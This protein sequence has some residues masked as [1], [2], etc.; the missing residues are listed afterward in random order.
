[1]ATKG[2]VPA[3]L[4]QFNAA[5]GTI[6]FSPEYAGMAIS[7]IMYITNVLSGVAT[8]IY[9]FS[10]PLKGGTFNSATLTL[11]LAFSTVGMNDNDPLQII[12][13]Y[14][15]QGQ[16]DLAQEQVDHLAYV[17][18]NLQS[19]VESLDLI[20]LAMDESNKAPLSVREISNERRDVLNS[21]I[22]S[23]APET[24]SKIL[25]NVNEALVIDTSGYNSIYI[26]IPTSPGSVN[27]TFQF[28]ISNDGAL[29]LQ[30]LPFINVGTSTTTTATPGTLVSFTVATTGYYIAPATAKFFRVILTA[31]TAGSITPQVVLR[32]N[33]IPTGPY[34]QIPV[35][36]NIGFIAG[37]TPQVI[38]ATNTSATVGTSSNSGFPIGG[39]YQPTSNP[40]NAASTLSTTV[41]F[42][43]GIAGREQPYVGAL[44]G[45]F[46]YLT[47]DGG[48]RSILGGDTPD[49]ETRT[50][51]KRADGSISGIPPRG[52]GAR[53]NN[54]YGS[55][56]LLIE[57]ISQS[58][59][60]TTPTL[61]QQ[62]LVELKML[63]QQINELPLTL[64]LGIKMQNEVSDYR[65]EEY[66]NHV[67]NQ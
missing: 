38:A 50:Q 3:N 59:G 61:L 2:V 9:D 39:I 29:W 41:P 11:D 24:Y 34:T 17:N 14:T 27:L 56:S 49:T 64:N 40:P 28:Q 22:P 35:N 19:I 13:G 12:V 25:T 8:V 57:D 67:N 36:A 66:N 55:Q 37:N 43:L 10:D 16:Q 26:I 58:E 1:M 62:I 33:N 42:P 47:V 63:N 15:P 20:A 60:D 51:S 5:S 31:R 45:I 6:I 7:D 18:D 21:P 30:N 48:G 53:P 4:Y 46:R 32:Q 54:M 52:V 23:D 65:T 44:G